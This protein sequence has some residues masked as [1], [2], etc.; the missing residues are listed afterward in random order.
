M[1]TRTAHQILASAIARSDSE[2]AEVAAR[3]IESLDPRVE[4]DAARLWDREI[5]RRVAELDRGSIRVF[6]WPQARRMIRARRGGA[7]DDEVPS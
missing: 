3:L 7:V 4:A 5:E 6:P 2:R 1:M